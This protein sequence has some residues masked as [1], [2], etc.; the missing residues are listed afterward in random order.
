AQARTSFHRPL[1]RPSGRSLLPW[2]SNICWGS[3]RTELVLFGKLFQGFNN[4]MPAW[5]I[6]LR[7]EGIFMSSGFDHWT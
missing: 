5:K 1:V 2:A 6:R 7:T 4:L 3:G